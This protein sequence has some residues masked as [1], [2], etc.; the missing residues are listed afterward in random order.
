MARGPGGP[1]SQ[2]A[3]PAQGIIELRDALTDL[4]E[5]FGQEDGG[6]PSPPLSLVRLIE[7]LAL[8]FISF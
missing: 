2:V 3:L 4:L 7:G 1:R 8:L 5:T 6:I